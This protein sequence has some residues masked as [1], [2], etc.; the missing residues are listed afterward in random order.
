MTTAIDFGTAYL[1]KVLAY[2]VADAKAVGNEGKVMISDEGTPLWFEG[3]PEGI[4]R[5]A[6]YAKEVDGLLNYRVHQSSF[7]ILFDGPYNDY[8][9]GAEIVNDGNERSGIY[10]EMANK[11]LGI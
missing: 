7:L 3:T 1:A 4:L 6:S 5:A 11:E 9:T 10:T 2:A 8:W